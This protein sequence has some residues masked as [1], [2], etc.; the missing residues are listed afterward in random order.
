[1]NISQI[2]PKLTR[3]EHKILLA[4]I[5]G[6]K[7]EITMATLPFVGLGLALGCVTVE[8]ANAG[9]ARPNKRLA[10]V[11]WQLEMERLTGLKAKLEK[12]A[13]LSKLPKGA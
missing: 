11:Q 8:L 1:M 3:K 13:A 6:I 12:A 10:R 4:K 7:P 2:W 9:L 5:Q